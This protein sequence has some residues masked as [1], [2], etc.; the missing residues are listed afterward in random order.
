MQG[1][2]V[3]RTEPRHDGSEGLGLRGA[4][5]RVTQAVQQ[6]G[7]GIARAPAADRAAQERPGTRAKGGVVGG[8]EALQ[9][10]GKR[11]AVE[12]RVKGREIVED[13]EPQSLVLV[14]VEEHVEQG[15]DGLDHPGAVDTAEAPGGGAPALGR[16]GTGA[17]SPGS[18]RSGAGGRPRRRSPPEAPPPV[19]RPEPGPA[20]PA[21]R[22][23]RA[24]G[25][26]PRA[27]RA[28]R[29]FAVRRRAPR[30][31]TTRAP[32][33]V[34]PATAES[35]SAG[36]SDASRPSSVCMRPAR[37]GTI[38]TMNAPSSILA[39]RR[40]LAMASVALATPAVV[41]LTLPSGKVLQV[42][43]M[44]SDEDR[45]MGLMFRPSLPL[46]R[47][48]LF[49]FE[50]ARLPRLL[51]EELQVPDRHRLA[52]RGQEGRPRRGG[53]PP[54]KADPCPVY[55]P[56]AGRWVVELNAG[57]ARRE[58]AVVGS[59]VRSFRTASALARSTCP[60]ESVGIRRGPALRRGL[61]SS[62]RR[63]GRTARPRHAAAR[64]GR[65]SAGR[66]PSGSPCPGVGVTNATMMNEPRI[67]NF[68]PR[69]RKPGVTS[70]IRARTKMIDRDL[71]DEAEPEQ[72][73]RVERPVLVDLRQELHVRA[74]RSSP[75]KRKVKREE[76]VVA[77]EG[78]E[79]EEERAHPDEGEGPD[80][81]V[82]CRG[83]GR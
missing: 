45:A 18:S 42:E 53:V 81:L 62:V 15:L 68:Q 30:G 24:G 13:G 60:R 1:L 25:P 56:C 71:E 37:D 33:R 77:E 73:P 70:P 22:E 58:G 14:L 74:R 41:P 69:S 36:F 29:G 78:A 38:G 64:R 26:A 67:A 48:M 3:R 2:H 39:R 10:E 83:R 21:G 50:T 9:D 7:Q 61:S 5:R 20:P 23:D 40:A 54:C 12:G 59:A 52:R 46:D 76:E 65:S 75:R 6:I 27:R 49:V 79:D 32:R 11:A 82:A 55:S 17:P 63:F 34:R 47:G 31:S 44:V 8:G 51:D 80:L 4:E 16:A 66:A 72:E 35:R 19:R 43:V 57:Q 28:G